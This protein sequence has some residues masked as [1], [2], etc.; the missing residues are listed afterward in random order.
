MV[1]KSVYPLG[2]VT[3]EEFAMQFTLWQSWFSR[4]GRWK[5][6]LKVA[7]V[8]CERRAVGLGVLPEAKLSVL[9][10]SREGM[11]CEVRKIYM[12]K[13]VATDRSSI[14]LCGR[15][16]EGQKIFFYLDDRV[17]VSDVF[18]KY[19][20]QNRQTRLVRYC[21]TPREMMRHDYELDSEGSFGL[22]IGQEFFIALRSLE[23]VLQKE[24]FRDL[25]LEDKYV[26]LYTLRCEVTRLYSDHTGRVFKMEF[27]IPVFGMGFRWSLSED[28]HNRLRGRSED[29]DVE[30]TTL[31]I[32][33]N[34]QLGEYKGISLR[35]WVYFRVA[36]TVPC[37][38][39]EF[40]LDKRSFPRSR[41]YDLDFGVPEATYVAQAP[42]HCPRK[43]ARN[44]GQE[45][46]PFPVYDG[47]VV[48]KAL[49]PSF[50]S[51]MFSPHEDIRSEDDDDPPLH[52]VEGRHAWEIETFDG[53]PGRLKDLIFLVIVEEDPPHWY[54][55]SP[56]LTYTQAFLTF[57][58]TR[59]HP[60]LLRLLMPEVNRR[61]LERSLRTARITGFMVGDVFYINLRYY[62]SLW[63]LQLMLPNGWRQEYVLECRVVN[64]GTYRGERATVRVCICLFEEYPAPWS[65]LDMQNY[66]IGRFPLRSE[67]VVTKEL[68][69]A[70][71][72]ILPTKPAGAAAALLAK[73]RRPA[74]LA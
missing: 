34:P 62:G 37:V 38:N 69:M 25:V 44:D 67:E 15:C 70:L 31:M 18:I 35:D 47:T 73:W 68:A 36:N 27:T 19:V 39:L 4:N 43:R 42:V 53:S 49:V 58:Q 66:C 63:F 40:I 16:V 3:G 28:F 52:W 23:D 72:Q 45:F 13:G 46:L 17:S 7:P 14:R 56:E 57:V 41:L 32:S 54:R 8:E 22:R 65:L 21:Y 74:T 29:T 60:W 1:V 2:T 11:L 48:K 71:P 20:R 10:I 61:S 30:I 59:R 55:Y 5:E 12:H 50:I 26:V 6:G 33:Q 51:N 64:F 24:W 9:K